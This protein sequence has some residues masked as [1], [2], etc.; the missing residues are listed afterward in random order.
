MGELFNAWVLKY[1]G[2]VLIF[3]IGFVPLKEAGTNIWKWLFRVIGKALLQ[4]LDQELT[5]MRKSIDAIGKRMDEQET[6]LEI[7][8]VEDARRRI[9]RFADEERHEITHSE[10]HFGLINDD[11]QL[12]INYCKDHPKFVNMKADSAIELI[13]AKYREGNFLT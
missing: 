3:L 2:A 11:I 4:P 8:D 5:S 1:G 13:K 12:Y 7:S 9:L 10:E 6:R